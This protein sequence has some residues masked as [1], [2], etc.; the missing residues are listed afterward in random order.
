M[1]QVHFFREKN[2]YRYGQKQIE[3]HIIVKLITRLL[4]RAE[5]KKKKK[6]KQ[7]GTVKLADQT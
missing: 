7:I 6:L 1:I 2:S 4:I 5:S 3:K